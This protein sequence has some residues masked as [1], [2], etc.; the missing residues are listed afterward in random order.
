MTGTA[1]APRRYQASYYQ[2]DWVLACRDATS[3]YSTPLAWDLS[4]PLDPQLVAGA[5]A[6]LTGRHAALR[7]AF[8]VSG[9]DVEQ[10]VWPAV[11]VPL[12]TVDL[13]RTA[14]PAA[15]L[16]ERLIREAERPRRL[17][18]PPLWHAELVRLRP[19]RHVLAMFVHHLVF[20]GWSHGVLHDELVR[21]LRA[22]VRGRPPRLPAL[23]LAVGE[24][25]EHERGLRDR[26]A[27]RWWS[28]RLAGLPAVAAPPLGGRFVSCPLPPVPAAVG[29]DLRRLADEVGVGVSEVLLAA[30]VAVRR[31]EV[32]DDVII[33]VT[34]ARRDEPDCH[35]VIGP[36]LDHLPVRVDTGGGI[37]VGALLERV[38]QA[39]RA[40]RRRTLPLGLIRQAVQGDRLFDTRF[41]YMPSASGGEVVLAGAV[42]VVPRAVDPTR[43]RPRH[44]EDHPEVLPLSVNLRHQHDGRLAGDVCGHDGVYPGSSLTALGERL[45]GTLERI[46]AGGVGQRLPDAGG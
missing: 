41:N 38:H 13:T 43:Q 25:A 24:F 30:V 11:D 23:R 34:R 5:L 29:T 37:T 3:F 9:R 32:G 26:D 22:A 17:D 14:D 4:G 28:D 6:E 19:G 36:L 44:T 39:Y 40:A 1:A 20:D 31:H 10:L 33:G 27:E 7:T 42:R 15:E 45:V 35:R 16:E 12:R 2:R 18:R 46:A 21:C 8:R